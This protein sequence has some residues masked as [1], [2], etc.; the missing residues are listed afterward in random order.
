MPPAPMHRMRA[1]WI[2]SVRSPELSAE[3]QG[4]PS[5]STI[6]GA[7]FLASACNGDLNQH[8]TFQ[9]FSSVTNYGTGRYQ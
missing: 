2:V 5:D 3:G 4:M 1:D 6:R 8:Y 9:P 7:M